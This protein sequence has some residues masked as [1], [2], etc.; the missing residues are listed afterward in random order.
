LLIHLVILI[1][2][3]IVGVIFIGVSLFKKG[4]FLIAS[5]IAINLGHGQ[6]LLVTKQHLFLL[7]DERVAQH[8][9]VLTL[10]VQDVLKLDPLVGVDDILD[11]FL[12]VVSHLHGVS[13]HGTHVAPRLLIQTDELHDLLFDARVSLIELGDS[14]VESI[15][16]DGEGSRGVGRRAHAASIS[17]DT[18]CDTVPHAD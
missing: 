17:T 9:Q 18:A 4:P 16:D 2:L 7:V 8:G 10:L 6:L 15:N 3:F 14:D 11:T 13:K 1:K 12:D 5:W